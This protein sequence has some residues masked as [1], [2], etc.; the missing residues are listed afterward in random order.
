MET[1]GQAE[2]PDKRGRGR[3]SDFY[4]YISMHDDEKIAETSS[5]LPGAEAVLPCLPSWPEAVRRHMGL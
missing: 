2:I 3:V 5:R 1:K 4:T